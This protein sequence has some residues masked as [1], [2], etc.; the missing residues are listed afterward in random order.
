MTHTFKPGDF[1]SLKSENLSRGYGV[2]DKAV[3]VVVSTRTD[4]PYR[5][6]EPVN[7]DEINLHWLALENVPVNQSNGSYS[8]CDF[9]IAKQHKTS[10][11]KIGDV[12]KYR[13][14]FPGAYYVVVYTD[15]DREDADL[16]YKEKMSS[17]VDDLSDEQERKYT[18]YP[19]YI[20]VVC[21]NPS[22]GSESCFGVF[23]DDLKH[24]NTREELINKLE[25]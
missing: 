12:V 25:E 22:R 13:H 21:L 24:V 17:V 5:S 1:V 11:F 19:E 14:G 20:Y 18:K 23:P 10:F 3:A 15:W 4:N 7:E 6:N 9:V 8:A 16:D 2:T